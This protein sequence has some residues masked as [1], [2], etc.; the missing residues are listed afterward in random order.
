[1]NKL[2]KY[3]LTL[4]IFFPLTSFASGGD[5]LD[6]LS[7]ELIVVI[8]FVATVVFVKVNWKGKGLMI[9]IFIV[10][11]YLTIT[12]MNNFSYTR[13]KVILNVIS[14][15]VPALTTIISYFILKSRFKKETS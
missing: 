14:I 4:G 6:W 1:M 12:V 11:E 15:I 3:L 13:N 10:T 9:L 7:I 2:K 8:G 5:V